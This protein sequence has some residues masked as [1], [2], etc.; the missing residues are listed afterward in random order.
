[1]VSQPRT[2]AG[3]PSHTEPN[4]TEPSHAEPS[5][6]EPSHAEPSHAEPNR[7]DRAGTAEDAWDSWPDLRCLPVAELGAWRSAVIVAAHPDDEVL[8]AGG[9]MALLAGAG[10]RLRLVAVTDGEASHPRA[11]PA[12]M[13]RARTAESAAA[14]QMLGLTDVEV[15][16]LHLP[17]TGLAARERELTALL[18]AQCAGFGLCLAPWESDAHAD[19]EAAGRAARRAARQAGQDALTYPI[20]MWHWARPG[21]VRVPW[22][23]A[24]Q[25]PLPADVAARKRSAI[26]AFASQLAARDG[27]DGPVLP[28]GIVAHFTR[29]RE[30]L[31]R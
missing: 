31:L 10:A 21:D 5:H 24:C 29:Q 9:T 13:G 23:R 4:H 22:H 18:G 17:D 12:A 14:L 1:V 16:R 8:G 27:A 28:A 25:V 11:D 20:W 3:P 19:H 6:T 2:S 7:I 30:V 26:G 15:I